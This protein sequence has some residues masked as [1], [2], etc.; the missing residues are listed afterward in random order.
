MQ[1]S[2]SIKN[3]AE[4]LVK[5][6]S[7]VEFVTKDSTNPF[8][9]SKYASLEAVISG[10]RVELTECGLSF[11]QFPSFEGLTTILMH[12]SGEWIA[13]DAKMIIKDQTP[14]GQGSA[15]TYM[16][17]YA[18]SSILGIAT[19]DDDDGNE[20][21]KP[22]AKPAASKAKVADKNKPW[23]APPKKETLNDND[24]EL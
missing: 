18:L 17:R 23:Q 19:E 9:K 12:T 22:Q 15:I 21:S 6:Q 20:A 14:Q 24:I 4:A 11:S 2:D 13:V 16:R 7:K 8:F 10:T 5:F 3:L 1:K